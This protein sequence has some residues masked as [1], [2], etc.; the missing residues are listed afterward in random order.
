[1]FSPGHKSSLLNG[2]FIH[3][4]AL[5]HLT[6]LRHF[7]QAHMIESG[8]IYQCFYLNPRQLAE[9]HHSLLLLRRSTRGWQQSVRESLSER[10]ASADQ[11][12]QHFLLRR[13]LSCWKRVRTHKH[14]HTDTVNQSE[15]QSP[16][17]R[18]LINTFQCIIQLW[19]KLFLP[20]SFKISLLVCVA[21]FS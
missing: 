10:E 17:S 8:W 3:R 7:N 11:L 4:Q 9:S 19:K 1:M 16:I 21:C 20:V 14:T 2:R 15:L 18:D 13:S 6:A 12:Y 5:H